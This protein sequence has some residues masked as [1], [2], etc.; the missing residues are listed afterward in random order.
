MLKL[1]DSVITGNNK[2]FIV[3]RQK[4]RDIGFWWK[5]DALKFFKTVVLQ[6]VDTIAGGCIDA[7]I[8]Y[9]SIADAFLARNLSYMF[10]LQIVH[11]SVCLEIHAAAKSVDVPDVDGYFYIKATK[12][13]SEQHE[14]NTF[15]DCKV[16]DIT[17]NYDLVGVFD[18]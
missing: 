10:V 13:Q 8:Q 4:C 3:Y 11:G 5:I 1:I 12:E 14:I 2:H 15:V 9:G 7:I 17:D 6:E 16:T 18:D